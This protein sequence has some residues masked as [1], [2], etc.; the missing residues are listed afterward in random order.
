M[1]WCLIISISIQVVLLQSCKKDDSST[2]N[3]YAA[4]ILSQLNPTDTFLF[5]LPPADNYFDSLCLLFLPL[6]EKWLNLQSLQKGSDSIEIRIWYRC[7]ASCGPRL[8]R[9]FHNRQKWQAEI[10]DITTYRGNEEESA[11]YIDSMSR[12][13]QFKNPKS[14]WISFIDSLFSLKILTLPCDYEIPNFESAGSTDGNWADV[15][16]S[17]KNVYRYYSYVD[18]DF[19]I[20]NYWQTKNIAQI[21][22]LISKEFNITEWPES[23]R[24]IRGNKKGS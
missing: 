21:L 1:K 8:V 6:D 22:K 15:E 14:G 3:P 18:P 11:E 4:K 16:I 17:T 12:D 19:P 2:P 20:L 9:F 5:D 23:R 13:I 10:S 7:W 24:M